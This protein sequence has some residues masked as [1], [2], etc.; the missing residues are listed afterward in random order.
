MSK[1]PKHGIDHIGVAVNVI[2]KKENDKFSI[3]IVKTNSYENFTISL[4]NKQKR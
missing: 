1:K 3:D 4:M 2:I